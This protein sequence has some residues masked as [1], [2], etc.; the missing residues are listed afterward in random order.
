MSDDK[1][2]LPEG[3]VHTMLGEVCSIQGGFAFKSKDYLG[4][5]IPLLRI[6]NIDKN[7]VDLSKDFVCLPT[8]FKRQFSDFLMHKDDIV[9][10]LSGATTGKFGVFDLDQ[11][12]LLNQRVGRIRFHN[13][14]LACPA[15]FFFFM[16]AI[17]KKILSE[18]YV[19]ISEQSCH[20]FRSKVASD[21][22]VKLP[23]NSV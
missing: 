5:G 10:A 6:S 9:V 17:K 3:W 15:F 16:G 23:P 4:K 7:K 2:K 21:F 20:W 14:I 22:G 1:G 18:A 19:R 11:D 13:Q 12:A 8:E